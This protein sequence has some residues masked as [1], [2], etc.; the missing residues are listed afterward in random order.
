VHASETASAEEA[1]LAEEVQVCARTAADA[2]DAKL[3]DGKR[4]RRCVIAH[5][6][7][8]AYFCHRGAVREEVMHQL[9]W[10]VCYVP[11]REHQATISITIPPYLLE[12]RVSLQTV[13]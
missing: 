1:M 7:E 13:Q 11:M 2:E 3:E 8:T 12:V 4:S 6:Q 9:A 10:N 5:M